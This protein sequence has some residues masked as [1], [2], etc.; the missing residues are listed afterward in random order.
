M[1]IFSLDGVVPEI[2][3]TAWVAPGA[4]IVGNVIL[5]EGA[6]VW[7]NAVILSLIHI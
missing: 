4:I 6:N 2:H 3:P 7:F 1:P 5:G